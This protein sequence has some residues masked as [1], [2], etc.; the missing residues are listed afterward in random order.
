MNRDAADSEAEPIR[1]TIQVLALLNALVSDL[2]GEWYGLALM[3]A[4]GLKSGTV[5]PI[6]ARLERARWIT[7]EWETADPSTEGRP[8][9]RLYRLTPNG[10]ALAGDLLRQH[11]SLLTDPV[12]PP[13]TRRARG[14]LT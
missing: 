1:P 12:S 13:G 8:R 14:A 5:Y 3:R 11:R 6:L 4:A 2:E 9:R 7:S 10:Y